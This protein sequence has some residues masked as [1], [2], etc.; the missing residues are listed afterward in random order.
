MSTVPLDDCLEYVMPEVPGCPRTLVK[1]EVREA[2]ISLCQSSGIWREEMIKLGILEGIAIYE[3]DI[4]RDSKLVQVLSVRIS[5]RNVIAK[6]SDWLDKH[7]STDWRD[8]EGAARYYMMSTPVEMLL[9]RKPKESVE[10][11]LTATLS[12][13]P[14]RSADTIPEFLYEDWINVIASGA[15]S[16]LMMIPNK[17][18]SAPDH[19]AAESYE[20]KKGKGRAKTEANKGHSVVDLRVSRRRITSR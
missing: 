5:D 8:L 19:S 18:W 15:K 2:A 14:S 7:D 12:L 16:K 6:T 4:P 10:A 9:N 1:R 20:F 13:K 11:A 17:T 3:V